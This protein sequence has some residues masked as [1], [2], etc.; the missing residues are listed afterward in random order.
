V[1]GIELSQLP[2]GG[3]EPIAREF[4]ERELW[5]SADHAA[6]DEHPERRRADLLPFSYSAS[7]VII[8]RGQLH[9]F[10]GRP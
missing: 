5:R 8:G 7:L 6:L 9:G 10:G 3:G 2:S 4:D 1:Y